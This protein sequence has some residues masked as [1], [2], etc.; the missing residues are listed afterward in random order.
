M[1]Q[2]VYVFAMQLPGRLSLGL[3]GDW[4]VPV[5]YKVGV[6]TDPMARFATTKT[7]C[8]GVLSVVAVI[9]GD[10][11][12]EH[13]LHTLLAKYR[14]NGEWF[15]GCITELHAA[16]SLIPDD[17]NEGR[18]MFPA[19]LWEEESGSRIDNLYEAAYSIPRRAK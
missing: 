2:W 17:A 7:Y 18:A 1:D 14:L 6:T 5:F 19:M 11:T 13:V 4:D 15:Y 10:E 12:R 8:P 3:C 9:P 16:L